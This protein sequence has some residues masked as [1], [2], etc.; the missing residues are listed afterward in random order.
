MIK[1]PKMTMT[2]MKIFQEEIK[3]LLQINLI[4]LFVFFNIFWY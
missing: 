3:K 2:I 4:I 1:N